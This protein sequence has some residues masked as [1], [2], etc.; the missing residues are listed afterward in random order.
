MT[1]GSRA[2][3]PSLLRRRQCSESVVEECV[4][5]LRCRYDAT[6]ENRTLRQEGVYF[7]LPRDAAHD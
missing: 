5:Y 4:A 2:W 3:K 1:A 6:I 7:P